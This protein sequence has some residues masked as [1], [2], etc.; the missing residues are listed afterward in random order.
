MQKMDILLL[1]FLKSALCDVREIN[2][3]ALK[4]KVAP[5]AV[6]S[7][8][9]KEKLIVQLIVFLIFYFFSF[10]CNNFYCANNKL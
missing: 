9:M 8:G 3:I 6:S 7:S 1:H 10:F 4:L 5:I 2:K